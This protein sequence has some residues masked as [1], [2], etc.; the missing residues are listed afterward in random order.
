MSLA[1]LKIE[2]FAIIDHIEVAFGPGLTI[3]TGETGA[4]KSIIIDALNLALGEK[5]SPNVIRAGAEVATVECTF[6]LTDLNPTTKKILKSRNLFQKNNTLI[7]KREVNINGRSRAWINGETCLLSVLKEVGNLLV[8]M[9]GQHDHQS[10][11]NPETHIEFLDAFGDYAEWR[12]QVERQ[13]NDLKLLFERQNLLREQLRLNHEKRELWEFQLQEIQKVAPQENEYETLLQEKTILENTAKIQQLSSDLAYQLLESGDSLYNQLQ[14]IVKQLSNL[15][16]ITGSFA[17]Q[18][19]QLEESQYLFQEIARQIARFGDDLQFNPTRLEIINQRLYSLQQLM[20]K[21]G[22]SLS[23]V[24][25]YRQKLETNLT[26]SDDLE[27]QIGKNSEL[28]REHLAEFIQI[29]CDLSE[30]RKQS[31]ELFKIEIEKILERLGIGGADFAV[32]L[33]LMPDQNG[34]VE[35]DG[36]KYKAEATGIDKV[37]FEISTNRG[38]PRRPLAEIV[39]GGEVSRIMLAIKTILAGR[40]QIPVLIFDEIDTGISGKI[41][42]K[43]GEELHELAKVHQVICIT[44][45]PQIAGLADEHFSVE[46]VTTN[47][48]SRTQ[49]RKL[50]PEER[51]DEIAKLIGGRSVSETT[52]KQA[53][54]LME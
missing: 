28:I 6:D 33:E 29:A 13:F 14:S 38:E 42:R 32:R 40:D 34:W 3:L 25:T 27:I 26:E 24:V 52:L 22:P 36:Q 30:K 10:L 8:D 4:G 15:Q 21:Y 16:K 45:L 17:E 54:E 18:L 9:H 31:A 35:I 50:L 48:R 2:N 19:S 1:K 39:S 20:K 49:I 5:A 43:V 7:L 37:T 47:G 46:K 53:R 44:H 41:A 23:D 12:E 51:V 11:L